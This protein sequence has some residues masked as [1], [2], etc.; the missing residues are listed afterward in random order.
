[1]RRDQLARGLIAARTS[2]DKYNGGRTCLDAAYV[3]LDA[4]LFHSSGGEL[5][6]G[7][8]PDFGKIS[9][10]KRPYGALAV[11]IPSEHITPDGLTEEGEHVVRQAVSEPVADRHRSDVEEIVPLGSLD[12]PLEEYLA[13]ARAE[14][15]SEGADKDERDRRHEA[16]SALV[17]EVSDLLVSLGGTALRMPIHSDARFTSIETRGENSLIVLRALRAL[18]ASSAE[19]PT[20]MY[21]PH[22]PPRGE[23][24]SEA[25]RQEGERE[26]DV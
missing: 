1:M 9:T 16:H 18:L 12:M 13:I 6:R 3:L 20:M 25:V 11:R 8:P 4:D 19:E 26:S 14:R 21:A 23:S 5:V 24:P 15:D 7:L 10:T 2:R 22:E 17:G